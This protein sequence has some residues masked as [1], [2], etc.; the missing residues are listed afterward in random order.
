MRQEAHRRS[1]IENVISFQL[2][3]EAWLDEPLYVKLNPDS[4]L[5]SLGLMYPD[6]DTRH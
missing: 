6:I 3:R 2:L 5:N 1:V 4:S